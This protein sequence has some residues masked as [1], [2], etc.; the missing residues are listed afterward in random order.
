MS[1]SEKRAPTKAEVKVSPMAEL[2]EGN[3][4]P[5]FDFKDS[6]LAPYFSKK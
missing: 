1:N 6:G 5:Y 4:Y 2:T 3:L